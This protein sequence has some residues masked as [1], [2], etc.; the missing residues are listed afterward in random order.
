LQNEE[1]AS[2]SMYFEFVC[3]LPFGRQ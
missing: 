3:N 2:A 1:K